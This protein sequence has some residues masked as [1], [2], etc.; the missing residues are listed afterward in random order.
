MGVACRGLVM[1]GAST[2]LYAPYQGR[3]QGGEAP[4]RKISSPLEN[5]LDTV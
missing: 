1:P 5:A 3:N 2:R 4:P